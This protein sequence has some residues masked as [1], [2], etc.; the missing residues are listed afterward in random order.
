MKLLLLFLATAFPILTLAQ[1]EKTAYKSAADSFEIYYNTENYQALFGLFSPEMAKALPLDKTEEFLT[2]LH[3]QAGAISS[4][5]FARYEA[6]YAVYKTQFEKALLSLN[7][8]VDTKGKIN[9][10]FIKPFIDK[11]FPKPARN[12]STL[13]LPFAGEWTIIWG[14]DTKEQNYHV[15]SEAQKNA[16]DIVI[17]DATGKSYKGDGARNEDYYAF[18]KELLAPCDAEVVLAVDGIKDNIPGTMNPIYNP[19][20]TVLL[21]TAKNE[22]ILLAHF[23]QF[24]I[25]VKQ[26]QK[27]KQG[28]VLGLCGNSG[29]STE[30]HLHFH[31]QNTEDM[32]IATGIK[33]YF[34]NLLVNG[35]LKNDYSP[36]KGE[37]IRSH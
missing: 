2:G 23:K 7:I 11:S 18:G 10:L 17:T 35:Q 24:S 13:S 37:K 30:P 5:N 1:K 21:K 6:S 12:S 22:Y 31:L 4:R 28:Q 14:G 26:G 9:G 25:L 29:N 19:G 8:S 33:C 34:E 27:V 32:T 15:E 16:F 3:A 36:V 20:N